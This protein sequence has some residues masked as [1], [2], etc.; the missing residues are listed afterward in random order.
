MLKNK[1]S[2]VF[3]K[4]NLIHAILLIGLLDSCQSAKHSPNQS[5]IMK[6]SNIT[7]ATIQAFINRDEELIYYVFKGSS[8]S[9]MEGHRISYGDYDGIIELWDPPMYQAQLLK[10]TKLLPRSV[11]PLLSKGYLVKYHAI[12][13]FER[14]E[15]I[16]KYE[17][18]EKV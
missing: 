2:C 7:N 8:R 4:Y 11:Y 6:E 9:D 18:L 13:G 10:R 1:V 12:F 15:I 16:K 17:T 3:L 14:Y 5:N